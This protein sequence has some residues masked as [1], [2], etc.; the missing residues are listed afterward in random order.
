MNCN[1]LIITLLFDFLTFLIFFDVYC[2]GCSICSWVCSSVSFW[3][4]IWIHLINLLV[5]LLK[6]KFRLLNEN[7]SKLLY[8]MVIW[9][10]MI[11]STFNKLDSN[12]LS[13]DKLDSLSEFSFIGKADLLFSWPNKS[14]N[15]C[16]KISTY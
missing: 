15:K 9:L 13:F 5:C 6:Q 4:D 3:I 14:S 16:V 12:T 10:F 11:A 8:N 7:I 1:V 2:W